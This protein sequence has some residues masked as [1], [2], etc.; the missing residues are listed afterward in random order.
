MLH[1]VPAGVESYSDRRVQLQIT[2]KPNAKETTDHGKLFKRWRSFTKT[3]TMVATTTSKGVFADDGADL[4][5]PILN[6][7]FVRNCGLT[8]ILANPIHREFAK[9]PFKANGIESIVDSGGFQMLRG[10]TDFVDPDKLVAYYNAQ[11]DIGMPLDLPVPSTAEPFFFDAV[12]QM[13]KANDS[14]MTARLNKGIDLAL[15][16]HGSSLERRKSRLDVL[17][18][19]ANVV[20]IAGL[21]IKPLPG[22]DHVTSAIENMMYVI[23]RYHKSARY[24]HVLGVTS[25]FWLFIYALLDASGYVKSIGADSVSHRLGALTGMYDTFDF[26]SVSLTKKLTYR[27]TLPC[28]CP[29]CFA[30][31]DMRILNQTQILEAHN[32]WA[33][34]QWTILLSDIAKQYVAGTVSLAAVHST[35]RL[36]ISI[37]EFQKLVTYVES[38]IASDK[39]KPMRVKGVHKSLFAP[40]AITTHPKKELYDKILTS[41]EKFHKRK[42]R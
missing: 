17:D 25:K 40:R 20:A 21:G 24:F 10:T 42:F 2:S 8:K 26:N 22:T 1:Y 32:L 37:S 36:R 3:V 6:S 16:S 14:Y 41:Y 18:R 12:S 33:R 7:T 9:A 5:V 29:V 19:P 11:A 13:I 30:V 38:I 23:H 4:I 34:S 28:N 15:I 27:Q 31:D 39:F 35:L